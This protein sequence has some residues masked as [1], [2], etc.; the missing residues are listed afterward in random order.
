MNADLQHILMSG[1]LPDN[2]V[3]KPERVASLY[4]CLEKLPAYIGKLINQDVGKAHLDIYGCYFLI[5]S[6]P[7]DRR[8]DLTV[9]AMM[10]QKIEFHRQLLTLLSIP[11]LEGREDY[12][13]TIIDCLRA[14]EVKIPH[15]IWLEALR[16][17]DGKFVSDIINFAATETLRTANGNTEAI[18]NVCNVCAS[19]EK[20]YERIGFPVRLA[21]S[22]MNLSAVQWQAIRDAIDP[23]GHAKGIK[24]LAENKIAEARNAQNGKLPC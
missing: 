12:C 3:Q 11:S 19:D 23:G 4:Q 16:R 13:G 5:A 1:Q 24:A 14:P 9:I 2:F 18:V 7:A 21:L 6:L 20:I 15:K 10:P 17:I 22:N 8:A